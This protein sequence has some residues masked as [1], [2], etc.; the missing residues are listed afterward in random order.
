MAEKPVTAIDL[1]MDQHR[2]VE[3]RFD[4]LE[5]AVSDAERK[6]VCAQLCDQLAIHAKIEE[7]IF[8]PAVKS[9]DTEDQLLEAVEEHLQVK[10][11]IADLLELDPS[12]DRFMATVKVLRDDVQHHVE[13]EEDELFPKVKKLVA[14]DRLVAMA[15]E[16]MARVVELEN[17]SPRNSVLGE[18]D[19]PAPL[20]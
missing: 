1:L 20:G 3:E 13:E 14:A 11:V 4:D 18:T 17:Q 9:E 5:E 15:Q 8:Y 19:A 7:T 16:M 10:R 6:E 2:E 12:E